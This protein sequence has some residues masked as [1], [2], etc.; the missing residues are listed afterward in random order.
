MTTLGA[1]FARYLRRGTRF[2][3]SA[4]PLPAELPTPLRTINVSNVSQLT[5]ALANAEPG[6]HIVLADGTYDPGGRLLLNRSGTAQNPIVVRAQNVL[7]A[8][9]PRGFEVA[10]G[11]SRIWLWGLD[12]KDAVGSILSGTNHVIRRCRFWPRPNYANNGWAIALTPYNGSDCEISYCELRMH[13]REEALAENPSLWGS[14]TQLGV[15]WNYFSASGSQ[16][17]FYRLKIA[18]CLLTGGP[19]DVPY[20]QPN[21]QFIESGTN[22]SL[23]YSTNVDW[24]IQDCY[25]NVPRNSV[26]ID[27]KASGM[28]LI[29]SH[30]DC[31]SNAAFQLRE[32]Q[33]HRI[34]R[35]RLGGYI[36]ITRGPGNLIANS[37]AANIFVM[38][39]VYDYNTFGTNDGAHGRAYRAVIANCSSGLTIGRRYGS[40][41]TLPAL[42]TLV[43][44]H[45]GGIS[46]DLHTGT[47]VRPNLQDSGVTAADPV[48]LSASEVGPSAPWVGVL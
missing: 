6:D 12:F 7:G 27:F 36:E 32:G 45:S 28:K 47:I 30:L 42:E 41:F 21:C 38:A 15:I 11:T 26:L 16:A 46:Y 10:A 14:N 2:P 33:Q 44:K 19:R 35:C 24:T 29:R 5:N 39:G 13:T 1:F 17:P 4:P 34:E 31:P 3:R 9:L 20:S 23:G 18:R 48:T 22:P 40:N 8:K 43:E 25:G 37:T